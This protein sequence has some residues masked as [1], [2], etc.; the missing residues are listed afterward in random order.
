HQIFSRYFWRRRKRKFNEGI[1]LS[2]YSALSVRDFVVHIDH[3]IGR[4][5]GLETL[6]VDNRKRECLKLHYQ[7]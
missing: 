3:G 6:E 1:A 7:G 4:Y 5:A 2:S